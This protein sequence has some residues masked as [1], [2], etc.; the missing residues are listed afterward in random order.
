MRNSRFT[1]RTFLASAAATGATLAPGWAG[2]A[3]ADGRWRLHVAVPTPMTRDLAQAMAPALAKTLAAPVETVA[4]R[5]APDGRWPMELV[6]AAKPNGGDL[7][8]AA[9]PHLI[10]MHT[11]WRKDLDPARLTRITTLTHGDSY[12]FVVARS[13]PG[14]GLASVKTLAQ[15]GPVRVAVIE[16]GG[17]ALFADLVAEQAG[18]KVEMI[19]VQSTAAAF[20]AV[21]AGSVHAAVSFTNTVAVSPQQ[22]ALRIVATSGDA[23]S[24]KFPDTPTLWQLANNR[25]LAFTA[26]L[27]VY[28]PPGMPAAAVKKVAAAM[29]LASADPAIVAAGAKLGY[30]VEAAGPKALTADYARVARVM[31]NVVAAR[32]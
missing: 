27:G 28:G 12:A 16:R 21:T 7:L 30:V 3:L 13:L 5:I 18:I 23:R 29:R 20:A 11:Y 31:R 8:I 19:Q 2:P 4:F 32:K 24:P 15:K 10:T 25:K 26:V 9:A 6:Y 17:H 14:E 1:R 22:A